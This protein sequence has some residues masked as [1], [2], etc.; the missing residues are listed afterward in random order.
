MDFRALLREERERARQ[1]QR[2]SQTPAH[3]EA[4]GQG[5]AQRPL[6]HAAPELSL[7]FTPD[8]GGT[9]APTSRALEP[10]SESTLLG[11]PAS[12]LRSIFYM[13]NF[14]D[15]AS[16]ASLRKM[17]GA[18]KTG[19]VNVRGRT[20]VMLGGQ[21]GTP[22][23]LPPPFRPLC[24]ALV[25]R[26]VFPP[27]A[28]PNH[29]LINA[30]EVGQGIM[31]HKDGQSYDANVAILSIGGP[32]VLDWWASLGDSVKARSCPPEGQGRAGTLPA[33]SVVCEAGSLVV[34]RD[35]AYT[36]CF[37]GIAERTEDVVHANVLNQHLLGVAVGD[38]VERR[39][40]L[41]F[42]IRHCLHTEKL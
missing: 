37:H 12:E 23:P 39:P 5:Q 17:C 38:V 19:W 42:T 33:A 10:L 30:Y 20:L 16:Q 31:P 6:D 9:L 25:E 11:H 21:P 41:S 8:G 34:F 28:P 24:N 27:D 36:D 32:V 22:E 3:G 26:A 35:E 7:F 4:G 40:R 1:R 29:V 14:L 15:G 2:P 18:L 13:Q